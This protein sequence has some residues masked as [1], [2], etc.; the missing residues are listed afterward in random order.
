VD[1]PAPSEF[2]D[3]QK[4]LEHFRAKTKRLQIHPK[5][6]LLLWII[7]LHVVFLPW[8]IGGMR[9][10]SQIISLI[11]GIIGLVVALIPRRYTPEQSG[12]NNFR[13][14][15]WPRLIRFPIFWIGLLLLGYVTTQT[16]NPAWAYF[17]S[18]RGWLT[19]PALIPSRSRTSEKL[20]GTGLAKQTP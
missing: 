17:Q 10:W 13:L 15:M 16:L 18:D 12:V 2:S 6:L 3:L 14:V 19:E 11:L 9:P 1:T 7:G 5:E 8:A 4:P 20:R